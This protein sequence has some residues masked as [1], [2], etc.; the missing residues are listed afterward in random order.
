MKTKVLT[1]E[2][3][4]IKRRDL[5]ALLAAAIITPLA[6]AKG[7]KGSKRSGGSG[8]SGKGSKYRGG[9]R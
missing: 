5:F 6:E 7:R 4:P 9:K 3:T 2:T 8:S 1:T